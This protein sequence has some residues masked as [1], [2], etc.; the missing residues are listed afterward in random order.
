MIFLFDWIILFLSLIFFVDVLALNG[1]DAIRYESTILNYTIKQST[2]NYC[3]VFKTQN[4][5]LKILI[6]LKNVRKTINIQ[7]KDSKAR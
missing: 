2:V 7:V 1:E 3:I 5:V 4:L 6:L